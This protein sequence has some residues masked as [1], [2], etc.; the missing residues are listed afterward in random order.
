MDYLKT[1]SPTYAHPHSAAEF[2]SSVVS[3]GC[4]LRFWDGEKW[5]Q[6]LPDGTVKPA[7][8]D[9]TSVTATPD[10]VLSGYRF[11]GSDGG[12]SSGTVPTVTPTVSGGIMTIPSGFVASNTELPA[13]DVT[14]VTARAADVRAGKVI[15]DSGGNM[16]TGTIADTSATSSGGSVTIPAGY[17]P[18]QLVISAGGGG[19]MPVPTSG[20]VFHAALT[21][22]AG[23]AATGQALTHSG[24]TY[25][26]AGGIPCAAFDGGAYISFPDTGLPAGSSA[27][28][29]SIAARQES[30]GDI[31]L[32]FNYG[33]GEGDGDF[34]I[35]IDARNGHGSIRAGSTETD[36]SVANLAAYQYWRHVAIRYASG[37]AQV[38]VDGALIGSAEIDLD[39]I[40]SGTAYI[41]CAD[42]ET[43]RFNGYIA[44]VRIYDRALS[45]EEIQALATELHPAD[46]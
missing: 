5:M 33:T 12:Y 21:S 10:K 15:V 9:L 35:F 17:L 7:G 31:Y 30:E 23:S 38:F 40:L 16:V 22:S 20:L 25:S 32:L 11:V 18:N 19:G 29:L 37:L 39:T 34:G 28:T 24:V 41:G 14:S 2:S 42:P 46:I 43:Y 1:E 3:S 4:V 44:D 26:S 8:V 27:R 45:R 6:K 36:I 13:A